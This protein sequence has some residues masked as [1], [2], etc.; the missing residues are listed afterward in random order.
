MS[1]GTA[2]FSDLLRMLILDFHISLSPHV[3]SVFRSLVTLEGTLE[4]LDPDFRI[5]DEA[6]QLATEL[7]PELVNPRTIRQTLRDEAMSQL[8]VL[9]RLPRRVDQLMASVERGDVRVHVELFDS[10]AGR[11]LVREVTGRATLAFVGAAFGVMAL[12]LI[13]MSGGP[14]IAPSLQLFDLL[15]YIGLFLSAI[16]LLRVLVGVARLGDA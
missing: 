16:V 8:P 12:M 1:Q 10:P 9:R 15:G 4:L 6:K 13:G 3:T 14:E 11:A 5:V 2:L 7:L